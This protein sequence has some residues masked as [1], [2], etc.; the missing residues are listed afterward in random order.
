M[1]RQGSEAEEHT[2]VVFAAAA[3]YRDVEPSNEQKRE[4][5]I[6]WKAR[7]LKVFVRRIASLL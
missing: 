2:S 7:E 3:C 1:S 5:Y 4:N 6:G